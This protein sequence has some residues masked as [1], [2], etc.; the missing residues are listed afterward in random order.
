MHCG[1]GKGGDTRKRITENLKYRQQRHW[2]RWGGGGVGAR[3]L[4]W[5]LSGFTPGFPYSVYPCLRRF[6]ETPHP[7]C[8]T[9]PHIWICA[10]GQLQI[11]R[12]SVRV[13]VEVVALSS[14]VLYNCGILAF[15][16]VLKW[17]RI[18]LHLLRCT[19]NVC[20]GCRGLHT[21]WTRCIL[22]I[23]R[24]GFRASFFFIATYHCSPVFL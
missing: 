6:H 1:W 19:K 17:W 24:L 20:G 16:F 15:H 12:E 9:H 21:E 18:S 13:V 7:E 10:L 4:Q 2:C 22:I 8:N 14:C 23:F 5:Y 3:I 11:E